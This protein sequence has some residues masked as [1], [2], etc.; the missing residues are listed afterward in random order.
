L[1]REQAPGSNFEALP[2]AEIRSDGFNLV[3][4]D[5]NVHS[6]SVY[7]YQVRISHHHGD[8]ILFETEWIPIPTQAVRF[9]RISP[10]P[11][12]PQTEI[13]YTIA[14]AGLV[15]LGIYDASGRLVRMLVDTRQ[16]AGQYT[17]TWSGKDRTGAAVASGVYFIRLESQGRILADKVVLSK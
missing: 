3:C 5:R 8:R 17:E 10:N 1:L 16:A 15:R 14:E 2:D 7:R 11:F 6:G 13:E 12:N 4:T 9:N